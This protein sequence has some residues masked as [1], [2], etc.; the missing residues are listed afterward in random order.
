MIWCVQNS[1]KCKLTYSDRK[2]NHGCLGGQR[3]DK[4]AWGHCR[5]DRFVHYLDSGDDFN[6]SGRGLYICTVCNYTS[7]MLLLKI[8][9]RHSRSSKSCFRLSHR[10]GVL[11]LAFSVS[12]LDVSLL[13]SVLSPCPSPL[14]ST[15]N[16]FPCLM[17]SSSALIPERWTVALA[18][19]SALGFIVQPELVGSDP[20]FWS[21]SAWTHQLCSPTC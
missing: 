1:R 2:K 18:Q 6:S 17:L 13:P 5:G 10:G 15:A 20:K 14:A 7:I 16:V 11:L 21:Q 8:Q 3:A 12:L 19:P 4:V 9:C